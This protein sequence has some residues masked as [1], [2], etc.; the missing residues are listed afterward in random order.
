MSESAESKL[1]AAGMHLIAAIEKVIYSITGTRMGF[2]VVAFPIG[3]SG[4]VVMQANIPRQ[5]AEKVL[6][7]ILEN[8]ELQTEFH[9]EAVGRV[10]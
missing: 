10:S 9:R 4:E 8:R 1:K 6:E 7:T 5:K 2:V 3:R